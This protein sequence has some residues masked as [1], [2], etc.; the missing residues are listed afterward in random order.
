MA[1]K[2][3]KGGVKGQPHW[4]V[5]RDVRRRTS[6][7]QNGGVKG[8]GTVLGGAEKVLC[9]KF[10][11]MAQQGMPYLTD[12]VHEIV[13]DTCMELELRDNT[14][15][16]PYHADSNVSTLVQNFIRR[17]EEEGI[18]LVGK[19]GTKLAKIRADSAHIEALILARDN[20]IRHPE[21]GLIKFQKDRKIKLTLLS[22]FNWDEAQVDLCDFASAGMFLMLDGW[23]NNVITPYDQSPHFT[24]ITGFCGR[25]H[26]VA[27]FIRI[28]S[29]YQAPHPFHSELLQSRWTMYLAQSPSGWADTRIKLCFFNLQ[30]ECPL[31]P[32]G[33]EPTAGNADGHETNTNNLQMTR[34]M[35]EVEVSVRR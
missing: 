7:P 17:C 15:G 20:V 11:R 6:L 34:R 12:E 8:G 19:F 23:P 33:N 30:V 3:L 26:L 32:I 28:G 35:R 10:A 27:L 2:K 16:Q 14:T 25:A 24:I 22:V 29:E 5:E 4:L 9:T 31:V 21:S 13:R 1:E 18:P